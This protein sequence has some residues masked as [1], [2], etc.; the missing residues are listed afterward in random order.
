[1]M[2][3]KRSHKPTTLAEAMYILE[4]SENFREGGEGSV[5]I[6]RVD[7]SSGKHFHIVVLKYH[8]PTGQTIEVPL[9]SANFFMGIERSGT[10]R[11]QYP[12]E[13][14]H[15]A[16]IGADA[17]ATLLD[18]RE[19][20]AVEIIPERLPYELSALDEKIIHAAINA[21]KLD[22]TVYRSLQ[23]GAPEEHIDYVPDLRFIDFNA[24]AQARQAKFPLKAIAKSF[25]KLFPLEKVP[26]LQKIADTLALVGLRIPKSRGKLRDST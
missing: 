13:L 8:V 17:A 23:H 2:V 18:R 24:L 9:H 11:Q 5:H 4:A 22:N 19:L 1:M 16:L 3:V 20:R 15:G 14:L 26:S 6:G 7:L 21:A 12:I 25:A 10:E